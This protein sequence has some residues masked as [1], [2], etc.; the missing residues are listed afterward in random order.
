MQ[1]A[2][3]LLILD[4]SGTQALPPQEIQVVA[5][6]YAAKAWTSSGLAGNPPN[7]IEYTNYIE[8]A[9]KYLCHFNTGSKN[10][11]LIVLVEE[12]SEKAVSHLVMDIGAEY[13]PVVYTNHSTGYVGNPTEIQIE[14]DIPKL[15]DTGT[16]AAILESGDGSYIQTYQ[17]SEN[18]YELE[19][20]LVS[21]KF[22]YK[23]PNPV[24]GRVVVDAFLSYAFGKYEWAK[25]IQWEYHPL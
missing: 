15:L 25:D 10:T 17:V 1:L 23:T 24:T 18:V 8:A 6:E 3:L 5:Y 19:Y 4:M 20:Q 13:R 12:S 11:F 16:P 9:G 2:E 22:H 14:K 21:T 7:N